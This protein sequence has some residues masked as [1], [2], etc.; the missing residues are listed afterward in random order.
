M[1]SLSKCE[2]NVVL[3]NKAI[4]NQHF[5]QDLMNYTCLAADLIIPSKRAKPSVS[6]VTVSEARSG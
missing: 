1:F 3:W 2:K 4:Q 5:N 6:P